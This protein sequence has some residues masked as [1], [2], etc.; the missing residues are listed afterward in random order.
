MNR[1]RFKSLCSLTELAEGRLS[2][3]KIKSKEFLLLRR[4]SSVFVCS[5]KCPHHGA[6]LSEGLVFGTEVVCP[7]HHARFDLSSGRVLT[8]PALDDIPTY[9]ADRQ[10]EDIL[11]GPVREDRDLRLH[12]L[13]SPEGERGETVVIVGTGAAGNAAA[14][15]LRK[16]G[17]EGR[18]MM[19]SKEAHLPYDRTALSKGFLAGSVSYEELQLRRPESYAV[20]GIEVFTGRE[21]RAV[22]P[23]YRRI[24]LRNGEMIRFDKLLLATG[25]TPRRLGVPGVELRGCHYLR[26]LQDAVAIVDTLSSAQ[27]AVVVGAGFIGLEIASALRSRGISVHVV[28]PEKVPMG[29]LLGETM[30]GWIRQVHERQGVRF[31]LGRTVRE[32]RGAR[33]VEQ[34]VLTDGSVV[35]ADRVVVGVGIEPAIEYLRGTTLVREGAVPVDK[36]LRT[37]EQGIYAAGDLAAV[38]VVDGRSLRIEH[39]VEAERQGQQAARSMLGMRHTCGSTPFFWSE[40][41]GVTLKCVGLP[42]TQYF[43]V[44]RGVRD[45]N[46]FI[47]GYFD[48]SLLKAAVSVGRDRDLI[49][50]GE[51]VRRS[52]PISPQRFRDLGTE[53][54]EWVL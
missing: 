52:I 35:E 24:T 26:S 23:G 39:W 17:Y 11:V 14:E 54:S 13:G 7:C 40:Q 22:E 44:M 46:S 12:S 15:T 8:P 10:G 28:A 41:H 3:K 31:S 4:G 42:G 53:L 21:V 20:M 50:A 25:G 34:V 6:R 37:R 27:A 38:P 18:V 2:V 47:I 29:A 32:F 5:N 45:E 51:L 36:R 49:A 33:R 19:L 16:E 43:Q 9:H 1:K 30:G 48:G